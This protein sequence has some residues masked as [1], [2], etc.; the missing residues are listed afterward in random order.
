MKDAIKRKK[1]KLVSVSLREYARPKVKLVTAAL[2]LV[3]LAGCQTNNISEA[4]RFDKSI[5]KEL[6]FR[7]DS[8]RWFD[9]TDMPTY[10]F[11]NQDYS[12]ALPDAEIGMN[13]E[14]SI[15]RTDGFQ[16]TTRQT[17]DKV[18]RNVV[19]SKKNKRIICID[20]YLRD[21]RTQGY[22][23]VLQCETKKYP[24]LGQYHWDVSDPHNIELAGTTLSHLRKLT[25]KRIKGNGGYTAPA[26]QDDY[27]S[28]IFHA[29]SLF[30][31]GLYGEAKQIYDLAFTEDRYILPSH[32][33]TVANKMMAIRNNQTAQSYLNHRVRMEPDFYEEPS[34][35]PFPALRDT[36]ELR[37]Q[38]WNYDLVQKQLLE[39]IFERDQYDRML[40]SQA[41]NRRY[42][43][44]ER[45]ERLARRAMDTDSTNLEMVTR[46]LTETGYPRK[47]R[48][49]DFASQTVW[50]IIQHSS[51]ELQKQY[52]LQ[53]E[54]AA[55]NGD[56]PPAM[57]AALK[58]RID[59]REGRPQKYGTQLGPDGLCPLLD[60]SRVNEW[61]KEVGLPPIEIK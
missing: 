18:W 14:L 54:E 49:G 38:K 6:P 35:C 8:L 25:L 40:W 51:L 15:Y 31:D 60:A 19:V 10:Q 5:S 45:V 24:T 11:A 44:P 9:G 53:L 58:D 43:S 39:W 56:L 59:V 47:S 4:Q 12:P 13:G 30:E 1:V 20:R 21:G 55:L 2:V 61:R 32:L 37:Q 46:I 48:V 28:L 17:E 3:F 36:F 22:V 23:Y 26:S 52:L 57:I 27:W 41:A 16:N 7:V 33:S 42:E 29:D 34:A 50:M